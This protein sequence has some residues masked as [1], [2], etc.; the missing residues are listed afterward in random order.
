MRS[1]TP[2]QPAL[3]SDR[4]AS[5]EIAFVIAFMLASAA[6]VHF[7]VAFDHAR[8]EPLQAAAFLTA[9]GLQALLAIALVRPG[10]GGIRA[11]CA[12][13][14]AIVTGWAL[15]RT[16]GMP[17]WPREEVGIVDSLTS[18]DELLIV[19]LAAAPRRWLPVAEQ[20]GLLAAALAFLSL[21]FAAGHHS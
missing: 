19:V 3:A 8:A 17:G 12:L 11:A 14:L 9:A 15:T 4:I 10:G 7:V 1:V 2:P 21:F 16:T 18:L 6:A 20:L 13:S 5:G